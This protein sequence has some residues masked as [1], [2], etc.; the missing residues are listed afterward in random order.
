MEAHSFGL[1][2]GI[3]QILHHHRKGAHLYT[4]ERFH[5]HM[6]AAKDNHLNEGHTIHPN[7]IFDTLLKTLRH[8]NPSHPN[9]PAHDSPSTSV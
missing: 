3:M 1:M 5:I 9:S 6:E 8:K 7:A 4:L 2:H